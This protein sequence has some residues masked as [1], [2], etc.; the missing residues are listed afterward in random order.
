MFQWNTKE[1]LESSLIM[2]TRVRF[3][4]GMLWSL[5]GSDSIELYENSNVN[6]YITTAKQ[7]LRLGSLRASNTSTIHIMKIE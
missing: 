3:M 7:H 5:I 2:K 1:A 4:K 6:A